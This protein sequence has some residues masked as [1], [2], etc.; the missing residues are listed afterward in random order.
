MAGESPSLDRPR[1][2]QLASQ[3]TSARNRPTFRKT[4]ASSSSRA[5]A[6]PLASAAVALLALVSAVAVFAHVAAGSHAPTPSAQSASASART[7]AA[8]TSVSPRRPSKLASPKKRAAT[9]KTSSRGR[10]ASAKTP[11]RALA[12]LAA[13]RRARVAAATPKTL[14]EQMHSTLGGSTQMIVI[15]GA[16]IGSQSG[17]MRIFNKN[18]GR[19]VQVFSAVAN[20]GANGLVDGTYRTEGHLQT[21]TGIWHIGSFLFGQHGSAPKGT[22]MPYRAIDSRSWWSCVRDSTYN[23]WVES[24]SHVSGEHLADA[25]VQYEYAFDSGYNSLPNQRII[26]RGTAIF[27]H[28]AEPAGN[29]LGKYTHGCIALSRADM[30]RVFA[31]LDPARHPTCAIGTLAAGTS[32]SI[33]SY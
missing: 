10:T 17:M 33:Y 29:S 22:T 21:P 2:T 32:T 7:L 14:P 18:A 20:F 27:I 8:G 11:A 16:K 31:L 4:R 28:C 12:A 26:G 30:R 1:G 24:G 13:S 9:V 25:T 19:W 5:V 15:T 23:T 6:V 3:G